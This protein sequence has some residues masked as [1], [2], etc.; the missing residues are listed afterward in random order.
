MAVAC[1]LCVVFVSSLWSLFRSSAAPLALDHFDPVYPVLTHWANEFRR[2]AAVPRWFGPLRFTKS[3]YDT[4]S[5]GTGS[6][7][8]R[9]TPVTLTG[10]FAFRVLTFNLTSAV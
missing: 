6:R 4:D 10:I 9:F 7:W 8:S 5:S 3:L 2:S 1:R